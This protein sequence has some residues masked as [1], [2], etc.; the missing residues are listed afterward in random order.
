[1]ALRARRRAARYAGRRVAAPDAHEPVCAGGGCTAIRYARA[2]AS[3]QRACEGVASGSLCESP[4]P[5]CRSSDPGAPE[6]GCR[7]RVGT[8]PAR[9]RNESGDELCAVRRSVQPRQEAFA[10][11]RHAV[12]IAEIDGHVSAVSGDVHLTEELQA[13][14]GRQVRLSGRRRLREHH[15]RAERA[16]E[17]V[18]AEGPRPE[19]A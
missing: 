14:V 8:A 15:L 9:R 16:I 19:G 11:H 6:D 2:A 5:Y 18:G 1:M 13:A 3:G 17:R 10:E 7:D 4:E 12:D